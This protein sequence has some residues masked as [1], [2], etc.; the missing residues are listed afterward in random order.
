M[1]LDTQAAQG[2]IR[3]QLG[4]TEKEAQKVA[5]SAKSLWADGFGDS[6]GDAKNAIVNVKQNVKSLKGATDDTVKEV[7]KGTMT[8]AKAFDQDGND[9]TKSI[10]AMQNSFDGLSTDAAMDMITSGFQKVP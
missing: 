3:A 6:V 5:S 4:L 7:T 8:I 10:N 9:I 2:E 1:A